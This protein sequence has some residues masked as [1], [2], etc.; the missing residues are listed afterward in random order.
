MNVT[1][2]AL[3]GLKNRAN[4]VIIEDAPFSHWKK[5]AP[6]LVFYNILHPFPGH[7]IFSLRYHPQVDI[8]QIF[9]HTIKKLFRDCSL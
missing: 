6:F 5:G 7:L 8:F 2:T 9:F 1:V 3:N 4:E